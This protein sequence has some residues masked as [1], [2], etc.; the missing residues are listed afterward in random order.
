[1]KNKKSLVAWKG[2][3]DVMNGQQKSKHK[4]NLKM[5]MIL[6]IGVLV[7][8]LLLV[9]GAFFHYFITNLSKEQVGERALAVSESV[10]R[11][12]EI[13]TAFDE[14][15]PSEKIQAIVAPIQKATEAEFIVVGNLDEIRYAH[16]EEEKIGRKMVGEDNEGAL[17]YGETYISEATGSLGTSL[18]A[19]SPI[20][21][22]GQIIGVVSVG[23]L[24]ND[25]RSIAQDF[26]KEIWFILTMI[27]IGAIIVAVMIANY[28][29]RL[30]FDLE[31]EEIASLYDQ[32]E[33][34]LQSTHEGILAVD[35]T[36]KITMMNVAAQNILG[37]ETHSC[38]GQPIEKLIP[39]LQ[40]TAV[41]QRGKSLSDEEFVIDGH[42]IYMNVLPIQVEK[43]VVGAVATIRNKTEIELLSK[44]LAYVKQY[45]NAL[46]AQTHEF[47]NKLHTMLGLLLLDQKEEAIKFIQQE[48][49]VQLDAI[50]HLIDDIADPFI[51]GLLIGKLNV[52]K[53]LK[54]DL[55][56]QPNSQ[57]HSRLSEQKRDVLLTAV[58]NI[59]DNAID[60][61]KN[62]EK[63]QIVLYFTDIGD[64]VI[65]EIEDSGSGIAP[66]VMQHL[67]T[68]GF[69]TKNEPN[70]GYGLANVKRLLD[71]VNGTLYLEEGELTGAC[72]I[73][74]VP[75]DEK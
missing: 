57:L 4:V 38:L 44:E 35:E 10:A 67:F 56:I 13:G 28:I 11:I 5:K 39:T 25:I 47:S 71:D 70:R 7:V 50:R 20:I 26:T 52:A 8:G 40:L 54:I 42:F 45:S 22:D 31:P 41:L 33:K 63:R 19:K 62:K 69:S 6:L 2:R 34:I 59:L 32:R 16:P 3:H 9:I 64:E 75:K 60:E 65:F 15:N 43:L 51:S 36:G 37:K 29:K 61:L 58:G 30:L 18:R 17:I 12:P 66:D 72:F 55:L 21:V 49:E 74:T 68:Q 1:M 73:I 53:E 48:S 27:A 24:A 23:F 46:R 14:E